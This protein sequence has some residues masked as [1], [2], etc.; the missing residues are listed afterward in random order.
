MTVAAPNLNDPVFR[1]VS[2]AEIEQYMKLRIRQ[3]LEC[4]AYYGYLTI[5]LGAWGCGAFGH[6][7]RDVDGYFK[8]IL[9]GEGFCK[10]F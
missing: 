1:S 8:E 10:Y 5:P 3:Y 2:R 6:D 7:A 9:I 4:A